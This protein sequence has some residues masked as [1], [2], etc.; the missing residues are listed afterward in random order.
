MESDMASA[1]NRERGRAGSSPL[2]LHA[3]AVAS[4]RE[5]SAVMAE[6]GRIFHDPAFLREGRAGMGADLLGENVAQ[7]TSVASAMSALMAS[8]PHRA[9]ILDPR[10]THLGIG[11]RSA[12]GYLYVTQRFG[13]VA[14][15]AL[16]R[17]FLAARAGVIRRPVEP[18]P[19][20][21]AP[22]VPPSPP[23]VAGPLLPP[24]YF[25]HARDRAVEQHGL[26]GNLALAAVSTPAAAAAI[27]LARAL[28]RPARRRRL[29][30]WG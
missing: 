1:V 14:A 26:S 28:A 4:A 7:S 8:E 24:V 12:G 9:N 5:H 16:P 17:A 19:P 22:A 15:R 10:F 18:P 13:R 25:A 29:W 6:E 23:A 27:G 2:A 20:A 11:I 30:A 21:P 3:W